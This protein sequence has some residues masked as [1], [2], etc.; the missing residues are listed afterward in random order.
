MSTSITNDPQRTQWAI[1]TCSVTIVGRYI[2]AAAGHIEFN[3][4]DAGRRMMSHT[5]D[6]ARQFVTIRLMAAS[7]VE[8]VS[9]GTIYRSISLLNAVRL[10]CSGDT[11]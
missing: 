11:V 5:R 8:Q 2:D 9:I 4:G 7:R 10:V 1:L 6:L 3:A